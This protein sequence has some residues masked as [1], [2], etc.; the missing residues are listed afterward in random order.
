[1]E[2]SRRRLPRVAVV[3]PLPPPTHGHMVVTERILE[4]PVLREQFDLV[5]VDI[6]DHSALDGIG[7]WSGR[8]ACLGVLHAARLWRV[9]R[10]TRP[11]VVYLPLSQNRLGLTRDCVLLAACLMNRTEVVGHVHGGGFGPFLEGSPRWFAEPVRRLVG[12]C[13]LLVA[14]SDQH[15]QSVQRVFPAVPTVVVSH[16]APAIKPTRRRHVGPLRVLYVSSSL[17]ET[18]GT[19]VAL[20]AARMTGADGVPAEW[21]FV[22]PWRNQSAEAEGRTIVAD[23]RGVRFTGELGRDELAQLYARSDVF[24]FPTGPKEGFGMVRIEAMAAG[25]PVVTTPAGGG[26]EIVGDAGFIVPFESPAAL[27]ERLRLLHAD[28]TLLAQLSER[29]RQ[30]HAELFSE[31][32]FAEHLGRSWSAVIGEVAVP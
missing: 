3:G 4:S 29:A 6:S 13:S 10:R 9:L 27:A 12:R 8:N 2:V 23:L 14:M 11:H 15:R 5:H 20:R 16:G 1:M 30:R 32:R 25:L 28:R 21:T 17:C 18:K 26:S 31:A 7:K 24:V 22:G 19:F